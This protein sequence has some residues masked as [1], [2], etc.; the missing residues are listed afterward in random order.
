MVFIIAHSTAF[1]S[2]T[3]YF[4]VH[5]LISMKTNSRFLCPVFQMAAQMTNFK[6]ISSL[7]DKFIN[8]VNLDCH[9]NQIANQFVE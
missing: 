5:M 4:S 7:I 3:T 9:F 6:R 2:M 1:R 8:I